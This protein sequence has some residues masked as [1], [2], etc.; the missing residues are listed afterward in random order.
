MDVLVFFPCR[1]LQD[2]GL[3]VGAYRVAQRLK[4]ILVG[5]GIGE[6]KDLRIVFPGEMRIKDL[7]DARPAIHIPHVL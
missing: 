6:N 4:A 7:P 1:D 2:R 3:G 5:I